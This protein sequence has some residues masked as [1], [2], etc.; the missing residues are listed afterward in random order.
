MCT[1]ILKEKIIDIVRKLLN[2]PFIN[3]DYNFLIEELLE[4]IKI[5]L[6]NDIFKFSKKN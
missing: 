4:A 1:N 2:E 5:V 3:L 6:N